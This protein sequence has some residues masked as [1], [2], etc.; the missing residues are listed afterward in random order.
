MFE[1]I[2]YILSIALY[3][4]GKFSFLPLTA[5]MILIFILFFFISSKEMYK[6]EIL[7]NKYFTVFFFYLL[8][9]FFVN[10]FSF[11][12]E[13]INDNI[14]FLV[15]F[16]IY[17]FVSIYI[18]Q[19]NKINKILD[20]YTKFSVIISVLAIIQ[21][22]LA[23]TGYEI[24]IAISKNTIRA[25]SIASEPSQLGMYLLPAL[26][27][28]ISF[29]LNI[30]KEKK[31]INGFQAII[32]IIASVLT[33]S[34]IVYIYILAIMIYLVFRHKIKSLSSIFISFILI[35]FMII[36]MQNIESINNRIQSMQDSETLLKS[37]NLSVFAIVSNY[38]IVYETLGE[39]LLLGTGARTHPIKYEEHILDHYDESF[40]A[41]GLNKDDAASM[42]LRLLSEFGLFGFIIFYSVILLYIIKF[43]NSKDNYLQEMFLISFLLYGIRYGSINTPMFWFFI[44]GFFSLFDKSNFI[45]T[46]KKKSIRKTQ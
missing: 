1:I 41:I 28:S 10:I 46:Y 21:Y 26:Y 13:T 39:N 31:Y 29:F 16:F 30:K 5:S 6:K 12:Y 9:V 33:F 2:L 38:L 3:G 14:K 40:R 27:T 11:S 43:K 44:S 32:V 42:I 23:I 19:T 34:L 8:L 20:I 17:A 7:I 37:D 15:Y 35:T 36:M 18:F 22:I 45:L 25:T 4:F 24:G